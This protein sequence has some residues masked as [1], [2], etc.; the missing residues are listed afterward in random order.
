M[1]NMDAVDGFFPLFV[2]YLYSVDACVS[3]GQFRPWMGCKRSE[4]QILSPR[5]DT[6]VTDQKHSI[7]WGVLRA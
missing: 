6:G 2:N 7:F 4:V 5:L 1:D 3:H